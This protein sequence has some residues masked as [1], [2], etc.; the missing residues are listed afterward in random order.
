LSVIA[1]VTVP[2]LAEHEIVEDIVDETGGRGNLRDYFIPCIVGRN[3]TVV[4]LKT[5]DN[6]G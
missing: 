1:A 2:V 6:T 4:H 3:H 5:V